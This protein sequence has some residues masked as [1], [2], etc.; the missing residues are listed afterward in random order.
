MEDMKN[1]AHKWRPFLD[2]RAFVHTLGLK[3]SAEWNS[4]CKSRKKPSDIPSA[5]HHIYRT[6]FKG[7]GDWLGTGTIAPRDR[8]HQYRP[9]AEA[10]AF[11][12]GLNLKNN[13][14][15]RDYCRS[16]RKPTDIP[17]NPDRAYG[18]KFQGFG[19]WLGTG[20]P[21]PRNYTF[22]PFAEA[23]TFAH[24]LKLK[25]HKEW[26]TYC[27][28]G[29]KPSDIPSAPNETYGTEFI[30]W[31][32]WLGT[33]YISNRHRKR[34]P[35][36]EARAFVHTLGLRNQKEWVE[37]CTS[38]NKPEDIPTNPHRA[39][40]SEFKGM[41][42]WLGTGN[43]HSRDLVFRPYAE[44]RAFV[45]TLGLKNHKEWQAYC[46]SGK[47]PSD[48]PSAPDQEYDTDFK[49]YGDWLGTGRISHWNRQYLPFDKARS[50]V[51]ALGLKNQDEWGIYCKSGKK[52]DEIPGDPRAIYGTEFRG[53]GDWLG[54]INKWNK[55]ALLS[56]LYDLRSRLDQL[57]ERELYV[58]LQQ[59]GVFPR[60]RMALQ[61]ASPLRVLKDLKDNEGKELEWAL[62]GMTDD[63]IAAPEDDSMTSDAVA[64]VGDLVT[65]E[66]TH[67]FER[68]DDSIEDSQ[69][70]SPI[71]NNTSNTNM[72][73]QFPTLATKES[74]RVIDLLNGLSCG[75][76]DIA[77]EYLI[78]NRVSTLWE[79][80]INEGRT[81]VDELLA[82]D[83]GYWFSEIKSR[84]LSEVEGV[85]SLVIPPGWSFTVNG[86]KPALPNA[87]Q[88]RTAWAV[89]EKRR[90][91]NWSGVGAGKTLSAVL[92]SRVI[93]AHETLVV[94]NNATLEGWQNQIK[95]AYPDSVVS[96]NVNDALVLNRDHYNYIILN[97]EKFQGNNRNHLV[98]LLLGLNLDFIVFDE[99]QF[100]KQRDTAASNR[101]KALEALVCGAAE[102]NPN[103]RVLGMSATPVINNLLEAKKLLEIVTGMQFTEVDTGAT[104]NNALAMHR[105]L[106]LHGFR[107][108]PCYEQEMR[109]EMV[110]TSRNDLLETLRGISGNVLHLEQVLLPAKLEAARP[111]L[112]PGTIVYAHYVDEIVAPI[113]SYLEDMGFK[114]GL[115]TGVDKSG[116]ASFLSGK[117]DVL[118]GTKP[119]G[120]GLD[121]LQRVCNRIVMLC[122]PWTSAEYEQIIGRI[123]R[124]GSCFGE[125]EIIIPQVTLDYEGD[126]WSWDQGRMACIQYKRTLSDCAVDGYIPETVRIDQNILLKQSREAL[127][128]WIERIGEYGLL[129]IERQRLT[130]P[131]PPDL[132]QKILVRH[133]NFTILNRKWNTSR[134]MTTHE[135]IQHDPSEW[136][137]YHT[138]YREMRKDWPEQ[139]SERIAE[140][141]RV[142]PD[143]VVADFGCGEC[144]LKHMLS[145]NLVM[146][147][148]HVAWD[149]SVIAC[150]M[151]STPLE[152]ATLDVAV[153]S[154]SL[155]GTNW[156][157]YLKEA[158]RTL[159]P[160]GHLFIAE[161]LRKWQEHIEDLK[162]AVRTQGFSLLGTI[163]QRYDFI[164]LTAIK[165]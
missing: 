146:S 92:A 29:K 84:F 21:G 101:R 110:T 10:R 63:E 14:E 141:I 27:A 104:V 107:Y 67:I 138:L 119:L 109:M 26:S 99:V 147:I 72:I 51:H 134:S 20:R 12:H 5:P 165:E 22:L 149:E 17:V 79:C 123:R 93:G 36:T 47:K 80:Y 78:A 126:T 68:I 116:L 53:M 1:N 76:D 160:Y 120:T 85:E 30:G 112:R 96:T 43:V 71:S 57:A 137:L 128:R 158:Y 94:T 159:K 49:G 89:R 75:L 41:G 50:F 61:G 3:S 117:V 105:M 31:G 28:S 154:L 86:R 115:Y 100:V 48:I 46:K 155:M 98:H 69:K 139:P 13:A 52:P 156:V 82:G 157:D 32:N 64:E 164:Y 152:N 19:D 66:D 11:V 125:V 133:G 103:L 16:G 161:P 74:L 73:K 37:Y 111:Y 33:G 151:S 106:M 59:G 58:I 18:S 88:C 55:N 91:G 35:F 83:G 102:I 34:R 148:D 65:L 135:R 23:R 56:L 7:M 38:G 77:A 60:L 113:R 70:C 25:N 162:H 145:N 9:F 118:V 90:V 142:R 114:V 132:R 54:V 136:Y 40:K 6:E 150:D 144:L 143:W 130:V 121:G 97:Y 87:M 45:H 153:F 124:Q 81:L 131:L 42:D 122:L 95:D 39:Y 24:S 44:A 127:E 129:A 163:E 140:R 4:Y 15:W 62:K 108:R 2:A 8:H